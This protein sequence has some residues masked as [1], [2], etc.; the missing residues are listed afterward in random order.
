MNHLF[1]YIK[2]RPVAID[3]DVGCGWFFGFFLGKMLQVEEQNNPFEAPNFRPLAVPSIR[4]VKGSA[5]NL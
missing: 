4:D 2:G 5:A 3:E 1:S